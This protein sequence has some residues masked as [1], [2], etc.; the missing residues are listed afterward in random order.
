MD[1]TKPFIKW[2]GGKTQIIDNVLNTFPAIMNNYYEIFLGGG[3]VLLSLLNKIESNDITI[4]K[5]IYACDINEALIYTYINIQ[6]NIKS[7]IKYLKKYKD[8]YESIDG[9][10]IIK[11][12][13]DKSDSLTSQ[14]SYYYYIRNKYNS[15]DDKQ[16]IKA[17]ALFIFLNKTCFRGMFRESKNGFNVP[18]GHYK[19]P[20]IYNKEHLKSISK[21]IKDVK[22][23]HVDCMKILQKPKKG[24]FIYLDPPYFP[25]KTT[26]F[27]KYTIND[28]GIDKHK[29]LFERLIELNDEKIN[30]VLNNSN[31]EF[32]KNYFTNK[33]H[34]T[35]II[36]D[37]KRRINAKN[38]ESVC[39]EI[40]IV[41]KQN[42]II[43]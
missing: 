29:M 28:F 20:E 8:V 14:E 2:I 5:N 22:F 9:D 31:V 16:S 1:N 11:K 21:L 37:C 41:S 33:K 7:L 17:S 35:I 40:I 23:K 15:C 36:I 27:V 43:L 32:V 18:F 4:K 6:T 25:E 12:A 26:S 30:F 38:P 39:K 10:I 42:F 3:S 24:D 34:F 13:K 19:K